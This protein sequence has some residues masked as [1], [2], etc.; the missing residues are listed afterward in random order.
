MGVSLASEIQEGKPFSSIV[1]LILGLPD[2]VMLNGRAAI[3]QKRVGFNDQQDPPFS[4]LLSI[5]SQSIQAGIGVNTKFGRFVEVNGAAEMAYFWKDAKA[6]YINIG[7]D[8]PETDRIKANI[9]NIFDAYAYLMLSA[10]GVRFGAGAKWEQSGDLGKAF[11]YGFKAYLDLYARFNFKPS[12]MGGGIA[13]GGEA[14]V[15]VSKFKLAF[16]LDAYLQAETYKPKQIKG[17]LDV[18][19]ELP[20]PLKSKGLH[21]EFN[22]IYETER[23]TDPLHILPTE[24][25][26]AQAIQAINMLTG[27]VF[28]MGN[29]N[30]SYASMDDYPVIPA[31]SFVDVTFMN[32]PR[33]NITASDSIVIGGEVTA[34]NHSQLIPPQKGISEQVRHTFEIN[35]VKIEAHNGSSW[36][37]YNV[38]E[39]SDTIKAI[40]EIVTALGSNANYLKTLPQAFWQLSTAGSNTTLR[41]MA[42]NMF[43][44]LNQNLKGSI[45]IERLGYEG[46]VVFCEQSK[47][48]EK[49]INWDNVNVGDTYNAN[50]Y[51]NKDGVRFMVYTKDGAVQELNLYSLNNGLEFSETDGV[52]LV[53]SEPQGVVK[54]KLSVPSGNY[55][56]V[57]Y[58][59]KT[60]D[61]VDHN[62]F[63]IEKYISLRTDKLNASQVAA[64]AG[65]TDDEAPV[66]KVR[67]TYYKTDMLNSDHDSVLRIGYSTVPDAYYNRCNGLVMIDDVM[68]LG[69]AFEAADVN[70][71]YANGYSGGNIIAHW[72][73]NGNG[74]DASGNSFNGSATN[75]PIACP[76]RNNSTSNAYHVGRCGLYSSS[77]SR[78]FEVSHSSALSVGKENFSIMAWIKIPANASQQILFKDN[79]Y[80]GQKTIVS[81]MDKTD[82]GYQF[83]TETYKD[84]SAQKLKTNL[85]F[86]YKK[87]SSLGQYIP[88]FTAECNDLI[89]GEWH[90]V[91]VVKTF[92]YEATL[93]IETNVVDLY[94]DGVW[95]ERKAV[96]IP[97][98]GA[99]DKA[100]IVKLNYLDLSSHLFNLNIPAQSVL[101]SMNNK[102]KDGLTKTVQPIWR[103][104]TKYRIQIT[105]N[106][107]I[108]GVNNSSTYTV[109]FQTKG[110]TG[111]FEKEGVEIDDDKFKL[112]R[113]QGYI[114]YERSHPNAAGNVLDSKPLYYEG[115]VLNLFYKA[116]YMNL[117]FDQW[118]TYQGISATEYNLKVQVMDSRT[119]ENVSSELEPEWTYKDETL[120]SEDIKTI[121]N[122]LENGPN[123]WGDAGGLKRKTATAAFVLPNLLPA[124]LYTTTYFSVNKNADPDTEVEVH[125]HVFQTSRYANFVEHISS[126]RY[127]RP[128][129]I[130][131]VQVVEDFNGGTGSFSASSGSSLSMSQ[132][133]LVESSHNPAA[134]FTFSTIYGVPYEVVSGLKGYSYNFGGKSDFYC[135]ID[136]YPLYSGNLMNL[137][138]EP[139][140]LVYRFY[141]EK[142][143][144]TNVE[145]GLKNNKIGMLQHFVLDWM[146]VRV[147]V[148]NEV[149]VNKTFTEGSLDGFQG[150]S[151]STI[152]NAGNEL[153][154]EN[155]N[156]PK[157]GIY[158][159]TLEGVTYTITFDILAASAN[160]GGSQDLFASIGGGMLSQLLNVSGSFPQTLTC[161]FTANSSGTKLLEIYF[162]SP[163]TLGTT[164]SFDIDNFK[165]EH[166][167]S[168]AFDLIGTDFSSGPG[169]LGVNILSHFEPQG[170]LYVESDS[171]VPTV[172]MPLTLEANAKYNLKF[173]VP[174]QSYNEGELKMRIQAGSLFDEELEAGTGAE[175]TFDFETTTSESVDLK[176]SLKDASSSELEYFM[177]DDFSLTY[178]KTDDVVV[179]SMFERT[180]ELDSGN[181]DAFKAILNDSEEQDTEWLA[182]LPLKYDRLIA[183]PLGSFQACE[184]LEI[185][186]FINQADDDALLGLIIRSPEP[187]FMPNLEGA[188]LENSLTVTCELPESAGTVSEFKLVYSKD[189]TSVFITNS[190]MDIPYGEYHFD[191][192][193]LTY[194]GA[195]YAVKQPLTDEY[196]LVV[197]VI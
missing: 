80:I 134:Q 127:N 71:V 120:E 101:N 181:V 173:K 150:L 146:K 195:S 54:P 19:L 87:D 153:H 9:D 152:S 183:A 109:N 40:P 65:Y 49:E 8:L 82:G 133:V 103:P 111:Y 151:G 21:L 161:S 32:S 137:D 35:G 23:D 16:L 28:S 167:V 90:H 105:G 164:E 186:K 142:T 69:K 17:G 33:L 121:N 15:N 56:H 60:V 67:I 38:F 124:N 108:D 171:T 192:K 22:W 159:D 193:Y 119:A 6:W 34:V 143:G 45:E 66:F 194:N 138:R 144:D 81:K 132:M 31:D 141:S 70:D 61:G 158:F 185:Q 26:D 104:D 196:E 172:E 110:A 135:K 3:M 39:A 64:Y 52:E 85:C 149:L 182:A 187:L 24:T 116:P 7:K 155:I 128:E 37:A 12:H 189:R 100:A 123:C 131:G 178:S 88:K 51:Y 175:L 18:K 107:I 20:K 47:I 94:V 89:D 59:G 57:E 117:M 102:M 46:G 1:T 112:G 5:D 177:L 13:M 140:E 63:P 48:Q 139:Q 106:E 58:I 92:G 126:F 165:I 2:V 166:S 76:G 68:L 176:I 99:S 42:D 163:T 174:A 30:A 83:Y 98:S 113:I 73:L 27:E 44:Y 148:F 74:N 95:L 55:L 14:F 78:Y 129:T 29:L 156:A 169:G 50:Q 4:V 115:A 160:G 190:D 162:D 75:S 10:T 41:V 136:K 86:E 125:K 170:V 25:S 184:R 179:E 118:S 122:L 43:S 145:F 91:A 197:N 93:G 84:I 180:I 79:W 168:T 36:Q 114:D 97:V 157:T 53:F 191:F 62:N 147:P 188:D 154:V 77:A 11:G 72:E 130:Q 96:D